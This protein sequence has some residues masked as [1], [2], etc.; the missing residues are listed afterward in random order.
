LNNWKI[1]SQIGLG[2]GCVFTIFSV[3]AALINYRINFYQY[4]SNVPAGFIQISILSSMLIF[5]LFAVL[6][7][8]VAIVTMR[9]TKEK[10]EKETQSMIPEAQVE[11]QTQEIEP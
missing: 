10:V 3:F 6:S 7:F 11:N 8:V 4:G 2:F 5:L 1:V 9:S